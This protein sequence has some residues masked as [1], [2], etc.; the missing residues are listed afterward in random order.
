MQ[1]TPGFRALSISAVALVCA[2]FPLGALAQST[3]FAEHTVY[4]SADQLQ[5]IGHGDFNNDGREDLVVEDFTYDTSKPAPNLLFLSNGN[6]TYDAPIKLTSASV[7]RGQFVTGDFN[8]DGNL[9]Y[10]VLNFKYRYVEVWLGHGD[11]TFTNNV[12][13]GTNNATW[14]IVGADLNH[15]GCTDIIYL[16]ISGA[17]GRIDIWPS[18]CNSNGQFNAG[19][20]ITSGVIDGSTAGAIAGDFDGDG[21]P[22]LAIVSSPKGTATTVQVWYGD[23]N[24]HLGA[25][26]KL[27]DP[28]GLEDNWDR[29]AIGDSDENGTSDLPMSRMKYG[30]SGTSVYYPRIAFFKGNKNRTLSFQVIKTSSGQC[31]APQFQVADYNG[32]GL[33]DLVYQEAPCTG[34]TTST[35]LVVNRATGKGVF[36][37]SEQ[38][39]YTAPYGVAGS[40]VNVKTTQGTRPDVAFARYTNSY[41]S[42]GNRGTALSLLQNQ[43]SGSFPGC[44]TTTAEGI[45]VCSPSGS[46]ANS[47]VKF[48]ISASGPTA[49]R[50]VAVW[51][52]GQKVSEQLTHALSNYSFL[53]QSVTLSQGTHNISIVGTGWDNSLQ[54]KKYTLTVGGSSACGAPSSPGVNICKP[55]SGSTL[56][57]PVEVQAAATITGKLARMEIWVDGARKFTE[58]TGTTF[59]TSLTLPAGYHKLMVHAVNTAGTTWTKTVYATVGASS[60]C[61]APSSPGI[62]V[63]SPASGATVNSPVRVTATA[64]ITGTLARMEVWVDNAKKFTETTSTSLSTSIALG[65]GKHRFG[66]YAVNTAGTTWNTAVY[67]TVP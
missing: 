34:A 17:Y 46:T 48:S 49:M 61:S 21:K 1:S 67:A 55:A 4:N 43:T 50:A 27:T 64:T 41:S 36:G 5:V 10:A 53:D 58:S 52:D 63:C 47:P 31:P 25:P 9:D 22:D 13:L 33:N 11:G 42:S 26:T 62:H 57:S 60:S 29:A 38:T 28:N 44:G 2:L 59:D 8:H 16:S 40:F 54:Q 66:I 20:A 19:S 56:S 37:G 3:S 24:G 35:S 45:H 18:A 30:P 65:S 12:D 32:D 14:G 6:G 15:D 39:V 23:G 7:Q 51:A